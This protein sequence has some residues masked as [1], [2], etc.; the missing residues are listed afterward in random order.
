MKSRRK[1]KKLNKRKQPIGLLIVK[2]VDPQQLEE[3]RQ[4]WNEMMKGKN[5]PIICSQNNNVEYV[6]LQRNKRKRLVVK[7]FTGKLNYS[8]ISNLDK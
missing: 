3:F 6:P 1:L 8:Q 7:Q 5:I 2:D 4:K